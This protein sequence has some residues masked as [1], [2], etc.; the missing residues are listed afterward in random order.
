MNKPQTNINGI[1]KKIS[2]VVTSP[3]LPVGMEANRVPSSVSVT[4]A[5]SLMPY[6]SLSSL[7]IVA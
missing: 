5:L 6:F 7:G 3:E 4:K 1:L 2:G